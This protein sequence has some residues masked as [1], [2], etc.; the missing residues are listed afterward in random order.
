M[1]VAP[2]YFIMFDSHGDSH[3]NALKPKYIPTIPVTPGSAG[4]AG[5]GSFNSAKTKP[6]IKPVIMDKMT[7]FIVAILSKNSFGKHIPSL[8]LCGFNHV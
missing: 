3:S 2:F 8:S 7:I 5:I 6:T 1:E 4:G